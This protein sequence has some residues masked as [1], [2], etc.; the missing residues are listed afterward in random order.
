MSKLLILIITLLITGV[1]LT[2]S[3]PDYKVESTSRVPDAVYSVVE[4]SLT[5]PFPMESFL[6]VTPTP[7]DAKFALRLGLYSQLQQATAAANELQVSA[8]TLIVKST[9]ATREWY[10]VAL[11]PYTSISEAERKKQWL[12]KNQISSTLMLWPDK[13]S[14]EN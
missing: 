1:G 7:L 10:L 8:R 5:S 14:I 13:E 4:D 11:G 3:L 12:Q 9:D 2:L 6:L